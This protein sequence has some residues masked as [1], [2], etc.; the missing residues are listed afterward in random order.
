MSRVIDSSYQYYKQ[1]S[2]DL[3]PLSKEEESLIGKRAAAGDQAAIDTLILRNI[4][5]AEK[6]ALDFAQQFHIYTLTDD[7]IQAAVQGLSQAARSYNPDKNSSFSAYASTLIHNEI[8]DEYAKSQN[9][10]HIPAWFVPIYT[11]V[12]SYTYKYAEEHNNQYPSPEVACAELNI[13]RKHYDSAMEMLNLKGMRSLQDEVGQ[14]GASDDA[15]ITLE[16]T[17]EDNGSSFE[18]EVA[19]KD[20]VKDALSC[21]SERN[22]EIISMRFGLNGYEET[23]ATEISKLFGISQARVSTIITA[24]LKNMEKHLTRN[25]HSR[26]DMDER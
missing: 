11:K 8:V 3:Q 15:K 17:I 16:D 12:Q 7:L 20:A 23:S 5:L 9:T 2:K 10:G 1:F 25:E 18:E 21:L 22:R 19:V 4:Y 24:C 14:D 13:S 6:K 26:Y